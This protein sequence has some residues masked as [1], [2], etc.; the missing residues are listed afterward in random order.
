[1]DGFPNGHLPVEHE[2]LQYLLCMKT[3]NSRQKINHK[4][5]VAEEL[6]LHWIYCNVYPKHSRQ[7]TKDTVQ[8]FKSYDSLKKKCN[9]NKTELY[10]N[11]YEEFV[12]SQGQM[13]DIIGKELSPIFTSYIKFKWIS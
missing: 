11:K 12:P 13:F 7:V 9:S 1:M 2:V 5:I 3:S 10:W 4:I 8:I 6:A